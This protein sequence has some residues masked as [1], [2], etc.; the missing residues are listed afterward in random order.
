MGERTITV[1]T[2]CSGSG[3][4]CALVRVGDCAIIIDAGRSTRYIK[5]A[6]EQYGLSPEQIGGIFLTHPHSDHT[7]AL[8]VWTKKY[9]TTVHAAGA[10]AL[11]IA[12]LCAPGTIAE[13]PVGDCVTVGCLA[14][15]SFPTSHD[16]TCSVGYRVQVTDGAYR[17]VCIGL[18]TDLGV[19]TDAVIAGMTGCRAVIIESNHDEGMLRAGPYTPEMKRRILSA[20]GHLSNPASAEFAVR[21]A[22]AGTQALLLAHISEINNTPD[23]ALGC[24]RSALTAAGLQAYVYAAQQDR[25]VMLVDEQ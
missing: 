2:L 21:L 25:P 19:V 16:T 5:T 15:T 20:R 23:L 14:V 24:A 4:N 18:S 17:A 10:T 13:H 8:R 3:G 6:L 1:G 9:G 22:S 11:E 12:D 7:A